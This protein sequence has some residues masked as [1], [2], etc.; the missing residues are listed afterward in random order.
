MRMAATINVLSDPSA[1]A[2]LL[3]SSGTDDVLAVIPDRALRPAECSISA[4]D[5]MTIL[6]GFH[7][8]ILMLVGPL[9]KFDLLSLDLLVRQQ[10][11]NMGNAVEPGA[12][13][14]VGAHDVPRRL[15]AVGR[16][17]HQVARLRII[18]PAPV[19]FQIHRAQL[20]LAY[21]IADALQEALFLFL[22]TDLE[23]Y[24]D[25]GDAALDAVLLQLRTK[26][27]EALV[28]LL[29]DNTHDIFDAG[30][31]VPATVE[32]DDFAAGRKTLDVALQEHLGLF[33]IRRRRQR[34][35]A[36]HARADPLGQRLDSAAL[37]GGVAAFEHD[38]GARAA[39]LHPFLQMAQLGLKLAQL[40]FISLALH[41]FT[42]AIRGGLVFL[43]HVK[44]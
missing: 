44:T 25:Q 11:Q 29:V 35:D 18:V 20:P 37:A 23:P 2:I 16:R 40:F 43:R 14:V 38:D 5:E 24:L 7:V 3:A 30:A 32:D 42:L 28:L 41:F 6:D 13:F 17:E 12:A 39:C 33:A 31:I 8:V 21:R 34:R 9:G 27:Q 36:K 10:R 15:L 4:G 19:G 1:A 22:L 26:F